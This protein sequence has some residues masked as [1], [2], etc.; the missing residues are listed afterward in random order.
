MT[1]YGFTRSCFER[2]SGQRQ[3]S[4]T[5]CGSTAYCAPEVLKSEP[6]NPLLSD[7]WSMGVVLYVLVQNRL[8]FSDRDTKKLLQA[9]MV[10]DYKYVKPLSSQCKDLINRH[11]NPNPSTRVNMNDVFE[12]E[13]FENNHES[14]E[15]LDE[16]SE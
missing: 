4:E 14:V 12:H 3:L 7:V 2:K 11:F 16:D 1:D 10:R 13:W 6:Y 15:K 5:Y 8:P 9:Q